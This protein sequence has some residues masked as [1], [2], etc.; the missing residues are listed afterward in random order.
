MEQRGPPP[1]QNIH[2]QK[3]LYSSYRSPE[4][5]DPVLRSHEEPNIPMKPFYRTPGLHITEIE[6]SGIGLMSDLASLVH[7]LFF[8][9]KGLIVQLHKSNAFGTHALAHRQRWFFMDSYCCRWQWYDDT[10]AM[11]RCQ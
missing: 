1:Q 8:R 2:A 7:E 5:K 3:V 10:M 6:K 11:I 4:V 9:R